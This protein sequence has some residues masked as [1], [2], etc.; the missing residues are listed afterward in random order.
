MRHH[1]KPSSLQEFEKIYN[2]ETINPASVRKITTNQSAS[3]V[4]HQESIS[5]N[6]NLDLFPTASR[7]LLEK[8]PIESLQLSP[9]ATRALKSFTIPSIG[10]L[11]KILKHTRDELRS[12]GQGH[13]D[14]IE[15][16]ISLFFAK[17]NS[18]DAPKA[19]LRSFLR[20]ILSPL[21]IKEKAKITLLC[22]LKHFCPLSLG[23]E[24]EAENFLRHL[25][26]SAKKELIATLARPLLPKIE[27]AGEILYSS[28]LQEKI[29]TFG[30]IASIETLKFI[31]YIDSGLTSFSH[32]ELI[33]SFLQNTTPHSKLWFAPKGILIHSRFLASSTQLALLGEQILH[34]AKQILSLSKKTPTLQEIKHLLWKKQALS[35]QEIDE[36]ALTEL[37]FWI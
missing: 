34:E 35:W 33:D 1:T 8:E 29:S 23:E 19:D 28:Y 4:A 12:I 21:G 14:E 10:E 13:L 5:I 15:E 16:K 2:F 6:P 3:V 11:R 22:N 36:R 25:D 7:L 24:K 18:K 32:F 31:L 17:A 26:D 37:L 20:Y 9:F 27:E 30:G